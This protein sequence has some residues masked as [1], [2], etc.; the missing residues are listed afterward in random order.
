MRQ[1][2]RH[3]FALAGPLSV[4]MYGTVAVA[5]LVS[6]LTVPAPLQFLPGLLLLFAWYELIQIARRWFFRRRQVVM[7][8]PLRRQL[9]LQG[10]GAVVIAVPVVAVVALNWRMGW[11]VA[12]LALSALAHEAYWRRKAVR[13]G[14]PLDPRLAIG[15]SAEAEPAY[16]FV[17]SGHFR[18]GGYEEARR[19]LGLALELRPQSP[20]VLYNLACAEARLGDREAALEH[21]TAATTGSRYYLRLARRDKDLAAI[22]DDPRFPR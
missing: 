7:D 21:L 9:V 16:E 2:W 12:L 13:L 6:A 10:S 11:G 22:R 20:L 14:V 15:W 17:A 19:L 4:A 8:V 5:G 1:W 3:P 18:T